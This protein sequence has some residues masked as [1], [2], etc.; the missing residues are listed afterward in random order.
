MVLLACNPRHGT[1]AGKMTGRR[2]GE[3]FKEM[4]PDFDPQ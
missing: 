4:C 1:T 3:I 2:D